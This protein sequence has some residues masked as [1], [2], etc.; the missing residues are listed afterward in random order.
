MFQS[1]LFNYEE[2]NNGLPLFVIATGLVSIHSL[3]LRREKS[4]EC[5]TVQYY[6]KVSIHSLQLRREKY[7]QLLERTKDNFGFNPLSSITKREISGGFLYIETSR[8]QSTLFNY[9]ERNWMIFFCLMLAI[10]FQS[11]LFN[12]EERNN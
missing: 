11:T 1:T 12:Y 6:A 2:R 5:Y 9:E 3:Q 10:P 8:F 7:L 4:G